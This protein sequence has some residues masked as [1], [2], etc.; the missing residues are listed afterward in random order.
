MSND[1]RTRH[2]L[3]IPV[4]DHGHSLLNLLAGV[5]DCV[6]RFQKEVYYSPPVFHLSAASMLIDPRGT[7]ASTTGRMEAGSSP[8]DCVLVS[9]SYNSET[10]GHAPGAEEEEDEEEEEEEE[11]ADSWRRHLPSAKSSSASTELLRALMSVDC[12]ECR[13][14]DRIFRL[15]LSETPSIIDSKSD[16]RTV[17]FR[18]VV[19]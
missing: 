13:I 10:R 16:S 3:C 11:V 7:V 5:D 2:F 15:T 14:G 1:E 8:S 9:Q 4:L 19:T 12:V 6:T 18:E 17:E